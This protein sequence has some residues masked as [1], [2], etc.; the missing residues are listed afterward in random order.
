MI[1]ALVSA[2][3][4]ALAAPTMAQDFTDSPAMIVDFVT[5]SCIFSET[6]DIEAAFATLKEGARQT[7]LPKLV[8]DAKT[9][10]YGDLSG[11]HIIVNA[12]LDSLGCVIK[13][14]AS[15]IDHVGFE[16]LE[17]VITEEFDARHP[18]YL[19][20]ANDDPSPHVDGRDWVIDTAAKDHIAATLNF[21][22]EDGV[23]LSSVAQKT[24]E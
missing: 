3:L 17:T 11:F 15:D 19:T 12:G 18:G 4:V 1:R 24:Y 8:A 13:I 9:G 7:G 20:S 10:I 23:I 21:G 5:Q 14:P 6:G 16:V 2:G 22:T